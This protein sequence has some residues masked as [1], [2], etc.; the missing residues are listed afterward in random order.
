MKFNKTPSIDLNLDGSTDLA[1][2]DGINNVLKWAKINPTKKIPANQIKLH[3][4]QPV[5]NYF[6]AR[7]MKL[8]SKALSYQIRNSPEELLECINIL[9]KMSIRYEGIEQRK[10]IATLDSLKNLIWIFKTRKS[11]DTQTVALIEEKNQNGRRSLR[12]EESRGKAPRITSLQDISEESISDFYLSNNPNLCRLCFNPTEHA[13]QIMEVSRE[14]NH[15]RGT[16]QAFQKIKRGKAIITKGYSK[17]YCKNHSA[18]NHPLYLKGHLNKDFYPAMRYFLVSIR[19]EKARTGGAPYMSLAL[20]FPVVDAIAESD[21]VTLIRLESLLEKSNKGNASSA[22]FSYQLESIYISIYELLSRNYPKLAFALS[23]FMNP[24]LSTEDLEFA[25]IEAKIISDKMIDLLFGEDVNPI[26]CE[27]HLAYLFKTEA[28]FISSVLKY[29][30]PA[31][32]TKKRAI[33]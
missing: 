23:K 32:L 24:K 28:N 4:D 8:T 25:L 17:S 21:R 5:L 11:S 14:I 1:I 2:S 15:V 22:E 19:E 29:E 26:E 10:F 16:D 7:N 13:I 31:I 33:D 6:K 12:I 30:Q 18:Q 9:F 27:R 3:L 20:S